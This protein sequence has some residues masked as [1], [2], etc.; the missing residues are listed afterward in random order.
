MTTAADRR[1]CAAEEWL[2][3]VGFGGLY[4]VS[5][6]GRIKSERRQVSKGWAT[7]WLEEKILRGSLDPYGYLQVTISREG[8]R[9]TRKAHVLVAQTFIGERPEGFDIAHANGNKLDNRVVNL[10]YCSRRENC[11]DKIDHGTLLRGERA[12]GAKLTEAQVLEIRAAPVSQ[13]SIARKYSICQ[14]T[15]S[16]IKNGRRWAWL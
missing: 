11:L 1:E 5:N 8:R 4:S 9:L 10:R 6:C 14:Q 7:V 2:P 3:V 12:A 15:V 13:R 16:D